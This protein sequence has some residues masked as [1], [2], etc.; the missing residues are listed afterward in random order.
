[1]PEPIEIKPTDIIK[2]PLELITEAGSAGGA[3]EP[4][5]FEQ[6]KAGINQFKEIKKITDEL[7][8]DLG[9]LIP[10]MAGK[11][12]NSGPARADAPAPRGPTGAEQARNFVKLLKVYYGDITVNEA[13]DKLRQDFGPRKLSEFTGEK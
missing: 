2:R 1:M 12:Q 4:N 7:G 11:K 3:K 8:F 5:I 6:I 13:L 10:G 9:S